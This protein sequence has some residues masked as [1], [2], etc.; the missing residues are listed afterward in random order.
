MTYQCFKTSTRSFPLA[1]GLWTPAVLVLCL[2]FGS[3]SLQAQLITGSFSGT[4]QDQSGAIINGATVLLRNQATSDTRKT[5]SNDHGAFTFAGAIPG[6]YSVVVE[7]KGFKSWKQAD[8][9]L[10]AGD[11]RSIAGIKLEIG[12]ASESVVVESGSLEIVPTDNGERS[13]LLSERD[14]SRLSVESRNLSELF[15]ILPGVTT[16][17]NGIG[18]GTQ[19]DF[20]TTVAAT[21]STVGVGLSPNGAPYRGGSAYILDGAN[22]IDPGC[23]CWSIATINP[24]MTEEVKIQTSNFGADSADGPVI[25]NSIS[26]AG[27]S[28]YHGQAYL[29]TRNGVLNSNYW[30]NNH[31]GTPRTQDAYYYP[32]GNF[33][34]PVRIPHSDFNKSNKLLFWGGYEYQYQNPGSSNIMRSYV[35]GADMRNG[36]FSLNNT[37][38]T[39]SLDSNAAL[40]PTGF[41]ST[42]TNWCN[43]LSGGFDSTGAP[44]TNPGALAVDPGAKA[45]MSLFPAAN[46][47]PAKNSG[48]NYYKA[49]GGQSNVYIYRFR[50][51]YNLSEN[52]KAFIAFQQGANSS[53]QPAHLWDIPTY[54]VPFPGGQLN[55]STTSRVLTGNLLSI[56]SPTLTNEFVGAWG[57]VNSPTTPANIKA[58]YLTTIGYPYGTIFNSSLVA[59]GVF[60]PG[61]KTFPE[62][63]QADV[64]SASGGAYPEKKANPSF[65]DNVTKVYKTHTFKFG[66]FTELANNYQGSYENLNGEFA[67]SS[68]IQS[69]PLNNGTVIGTK[70]PT[71]NLVMGIAGNN[72]TLN[73]SAFVQTNSDPLTNMAYRTTSAFAMDDWKVTRRFTANIGFRFDHL[74]R[75]YDRAG[76]GLAVWIP[77]RYLSDVTEGKSYPG[78]SWHGIEPGI[79]NSGSPVQAVFTSP[80]LGFAYDVLGTGK[81]VLRGGWGEYRWTDQYND[82]A[83]PLTT[84]ASMKSYSAPSGNVTFKEI[85]AE[86]NI[87]ASQ[88]TEASAV[89]V[90]DPNDRKDP[91][92][93]AYNFTVSQ[94]MPWRTMLEVAYVG[95]Q[96]ANL[97]MGGQS[98]G[99]AIGGGSNGYSNQNK[100]SVGGVFKVDP[101]TGAAAPADP[102]NQS[103]YALTDYYPYQ[104]GYGQ[105]SITM[106]THN[107]YSNYNG[108]QAAWT[109]QTGRLSF[110]LNYTY[111]KSLGIV[112]NSVDAFTVHGN[113]GVLGIDRPQV[114]TTSYA[115]SL[116]QLYKGGYKV[117]G[118]ATNGWTVTGV[119]TWQAGG[120]LQANDS[121]NLGMTIN[122][123]KTGYNVTTLSYYGTNTGDIQPVTTCNPKSG[124]GSHQLLNVLCLAPPALGTYG[125]RQVGYLSGPGYFNSDLT[126]YKTFHIT[127]KQTVEFK[128]AAFNFLNHP[129]WGFTTSSIITPTFTTTDKANFTST[130]VA[131]L[132]ASGLTQGTTDQKSGR[133]LGELSV[134]YSF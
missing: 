73:E 37:T 70:N 116:G 42:A 13:A 78:V 12:S 46:V 52:T 72:A 71:A 39:S 25:M 33:G 17:A 90:A 83:G 75:W 86:A 87:L 24:D 126:I 67:F 82:Y 112:N 100:I 59:P 22:I 5:L 64:W 76:E 80:R 34:G 18:N 50:V 23:N 113:Y 11:S 105:N 54:G 29:Y 92:T 132:A 68:A 36:N 106:N 16:V 130:M 4:V 45:L 125:L 8:L 93:Y 53:P 94:Q 27:G 6:T 134:K 107:G 66:A 69:D 57:W 120:N 133:R 98:S 81:T 56:L 9:T 61:A 60:S 38:D 21:G 74:G 19:F 91:A 103:T 10:N 104:K 108:I 77:G 89:N 20:L 14:I 117:L 101:V 127:E 31:S 97:L 35:P 41:T 47:D 88:A 111:S 43:D 102:D 129:L 109:K 124:L 3:L 65:S 15:K 48:F 58:S 1:K 96:T 26:K 122:D 79:P 51:D 30:Q 99:S 84:A 118:G 28:N 62:M 123:S 114:V 128:A 49:M 63:A 32:G 110:N 40:C 7:A 131:P 55:N 95:S 115:Y 2:L 121:Q 119:T 85:G 44:I